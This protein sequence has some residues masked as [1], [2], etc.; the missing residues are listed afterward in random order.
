MSSI[1]WA[2]PQGRSVAREN[3]R[4]AVVPRLILLGLWALNITIVAFA[5]PVLLFASLKKTLHRKG[6]EQVVHLSK[7][8]HP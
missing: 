3:A 4:G 1:C 5:L 6:P 8:A 7:A 2:G